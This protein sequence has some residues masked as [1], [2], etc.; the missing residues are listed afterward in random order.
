MTE[1]VL[2]AIAIPAP[3]RRAAGGVA[4]PAPADVARPATAARRKEAFLTMP[5]RAGMLI[6]ASAAVYAVTLAGISS[7]QSSSDAAVAARRQPYLDAIAAARATNDALEAAIV[8]ADDRARALAGSY[9]SVGADVAAF[10]AQLDSLATLVAEVEGSAAA[11]PSRIALPAV[12]VSGTIPAAR[13]SGGT[14][15][16]PATTTKTSASGG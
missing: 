16:A 5:A 9:A 6:G 12:R 15:R 2:P 13:S 14:S 7:V 1:R 11:L 10:Q 8:Q 3:S 4:R